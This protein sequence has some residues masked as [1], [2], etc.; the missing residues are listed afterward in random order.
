MA[1]NSQL[2]T[3]LLKT[4]ASIDNEDKEQAPKPKFTH[5]FFQRQLSFAQAATWFFFHYAATG[6]IIGYISSIQFSLQTNGCTYKDL[7]TFSLPMYLMSLKFIFSPVMDRF[8][9]Q[10]FGK[11]K[12]YIVPCSLC[13]GILFMSLATTVDGMIKRLEVV[14]LTLYFV[15][16]NFFACIISTAGE[17]SV[18]T[19]FKDEDKAKAATF[20]GLGQIL[21]TMT[22]FN[23]FTPMNDIDWLNNHIFTTNSVSSPI[24]THHTFCFIVSAVFIGLSVMVALFVGERKIMEKGT[25]SFCWILAIIPRIFTNSHTRNLIFFL[26]SIRIFCAVSQ[27]ID[28]KMV[29]NGYYNMGRSTLSNIDT[30][31]MPLIIVLFSFTV[32][33]TRKGRLMKMIV[34]TTFYIVL[35]N[36]FKYISYLDLITNRHYT[37]AYVARIVGTLTSTMDFTGIYV[38]AFLN[39]TVN[40][41][42][43]NT[44]MSCF[45]SIF[46]LTNILPG[47]LGF[48]LADVLPFNTLVIGCLSIQTVVLVLVYPYALH[49]DKKDTSLFDI[50]KNLDGVDKNDK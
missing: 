27:V 19:V 26:F 32:L 47:T 24:L 30:M 43:G 41:I 3:T 9:S 35:A 23:L 42:V 29:K 5:M 13:V 4:N 18:L 1:D 7:S 14:S 33:Y 20:M 34:L 44:G 15:A 22:G 10:R 25:R 48:M 16:I 28:F 36:A 21:G 39:I 40:P 46:M 37:R 17:A 11:S 6:M 8:Y 49:I 45:V 12:T 31:T 38:F 50:S 2:S